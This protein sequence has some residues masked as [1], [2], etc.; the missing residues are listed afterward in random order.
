MQ[1]IRTVHAIRNQQARRKQ[2]CFRQRMQLQ[3]NI[4]R[5]RRLKTGKRKNS[6]RTVLERVH[7]QVLFRRNQTGIYEILHSFSFQ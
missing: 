5:R 4:P 2:K 1:R 3:F 6:V 7:L